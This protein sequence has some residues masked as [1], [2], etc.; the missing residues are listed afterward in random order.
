MGGLVQG[1]GYGRELLC[2]RGASIVEML[3][4]LLVTSRHASLSTSG[5]KPLAGSCIGTGMFFC[6]THPDDFSYNLCRPSVGTA[7]V[8]VVRPTHPRRSSS[9]GCC[10]MSIVR[11]RQLAL[12]A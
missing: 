9:H 8:T 1:Q 10:P 7:G 5:P 4:Q 3:Q 11:W 12:D 2:Y 6:K